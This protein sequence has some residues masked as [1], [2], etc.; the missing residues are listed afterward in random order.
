[1]GTI[2][3]SSPSIMSMIF[4]NIWILD[5]ESICYIIPWQNLDTI[6]IMTDT[7]VRPHLLSIVRRKNQIKLYPRNCPC[8][9]T[10]IYKVP[11]HCCFAR[12]IQVNMF[13]VPKNV[14]SRPAFCGLNA[15]KR[16]ATAKN[17]R[18]LDKNRFINI[19]PIVNCQNILYN[20]NI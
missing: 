1:M 17:A 8:T 15:A 11:L 14:S 16:T 18:N 12:G 2:I 19:P 7:S 3:G 5:V 4:R 10:V 20:L 6:R 9:I 13:S